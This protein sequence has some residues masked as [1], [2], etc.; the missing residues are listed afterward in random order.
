MRS[1]SPPTGPQGFLTTS[2][3]GTRSASAGAVSDG[4]QACAPW[5]PFFPGPPE[6]AVEFVSSPLPITQSR[7]SRCFRLVRGMGRPF[8]APPPADGQAGWAGWRWTA[9]PAVSYGGGPAGG[10]ILAGY[11]VALWRALPLTACG[12]VRAAPAVTA[13]VSPGPGPPPLVLSWLS[14]FLLRTLE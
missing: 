13:T 5:P 8:P 10:R 7:T 4:E 3:A 14:P 9:R 6:G 11:L 12:E 1:G 2:L